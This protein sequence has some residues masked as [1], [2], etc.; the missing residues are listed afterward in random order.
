MRHFTRLRPTARLALAGAIVA[1]TAAAT[2]SPGAVGA[3]S[4]AVTS[5]TPTEPP[6]A[7]GESS[8]GGLAPVDDPIVLDPA[9]APAIAVDATGSPIAAIGVVAVD[10]D[11]ADHDDWD[12]PSAG[13]QY[14]R[15]SVVIES[16][17]ARGLLEVRDSD[18]VLQD[19]DG[20]VF[21]GD[22]VPTAAERA[23]G[24]DVVDR[25]ALTNG[26][27]AQLE[28]TFEVVAGVAPDTLFYVPS[29]DRLITIA[30]LAR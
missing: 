18:F 23:A 25:V 22:V 16:R 15:I 4:A 20:F 2:L 1:A 10:P 29:Y 30:E 11:W 3:A 24:A 26:E 6:V 12:E 8:G 9:V 5:P 14:L 28:L 17:S 13:Y 19:A 7:V 27:R 21:T